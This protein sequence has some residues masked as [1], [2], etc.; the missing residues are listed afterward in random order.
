MKC[1][2]YFVLCLLFSFSALLGQSDKVIVSKKQN[3][4]GDV[5]NLVFT[6]NNQSVARQT[7]ILELNGGRYARAY[8][9]L[10]VIKVLQPG[11]NR[12][13]TLTDLEQGPGYGITWVPGCVDTKPKAITYLLPVASG[14][15]TRI[16]FCPKTTVRLA[17]R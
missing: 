6:A 15:A 9:G 14:K 4:R 8:A 7:I 3:K 1:S 5:T 13:L 11:T 16:F 12:L 17:E 10:P 2:P